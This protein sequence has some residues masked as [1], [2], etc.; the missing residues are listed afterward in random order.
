MPKTTYTIG[1]T[2]SNKDKTVALT[3]REDQAFLKVN[4]QRGGLPSGMVWELK[5]DYQTQEYMS[6]YARGEK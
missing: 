5:V 6:V 4:K 1:S 2:V 3:V